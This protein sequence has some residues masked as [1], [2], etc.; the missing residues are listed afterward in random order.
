[1]KTSLC[2][3]VFQKGG[4]VPPPYRQGGLTIKKNVK[5][6]LHK[7]P[8]VLTSL[9][10]R[11][12]PRYHGFEHGGRKME[13]SDG[14]EARSS[15]C[16]EADDTSDGYF[17]GPLPQ[18]LSRPDVRERQARLADV[19]AEQIVPRLLSIHTN[20]RINDDGANAFTKEE[21][22]EFG[23]LTM[24]PDSLSA[25]AY[26]EK[27][28]S[29]GHSIDTLFTHLLAPTAR[30]LG[31]FWDQDL[32]DFIDVAIGVDLLQELLTWFGTFDDV[33]LLDLQHRVL[34]VTAPGDKHLFGI[35]MV[36][37][38]MRA[39]GW[40]VTIAKGPSVSEI[41]AIV[42]DQWYAV[43]GFALSDNSGIEGIARGIDEMRRLSRNP[44][45]RVMVG[46]PAFTAQAA[47]AIQVGA[48]G[49]ADDA[50]AAVI[51]AKKLLLAQARLG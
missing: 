35:N 30:R 5:I 42:E 29:R 8:L 14:A 25:R 12:N 1:M 23:K 40:D 17:G 27:M 7:A 38:L 34:L 33:P 15:S 50:P 21:V 16:S 2:S 10:L 11:N 28:R 43:V 4:A 47:M 32:C 20:T 26:F 37:K 3:V 51:L 18:V 48:D 19:I 31:E 39:A 36:G 13:P 6:D 24:V 44:H 49:V 41:G 45:I 9:G 22:S 46:G